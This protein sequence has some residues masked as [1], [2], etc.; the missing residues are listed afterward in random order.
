VINGYFPQGE[1][2]VHPTKYPAKQKFYADLL[3][4]L[5][6]N[7]Q[8]DNKLVVMGDMNVAAADIDV[9][10]K[11]ENAKRWLK[12]G[13]CAFLPEEREWLQNLISWGLEDSYRSMHQE[14]TRAYSWFDY[15]SRGFEQ[16]PKIG[17]RIDLILASTGAMSDLQSTGIDFDA[18]SAEKP[19]DHCPIWADFSL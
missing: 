19:S 16:D 1:G 5:Q 10:I 2:R 18:R 3:R 8:P 12:T 6:T 9:G 13:K 17:L 14:D 11:P 15:R 4:Y 7:F